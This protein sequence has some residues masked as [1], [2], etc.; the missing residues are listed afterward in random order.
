MHD[1]D[2]TSEM[3]KAAPP[4]TVSGLTIAG[5]PIADIVQLVTLIYVSCLL[6]KWLWDRLK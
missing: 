3:I 5:I 6:G 2:F 4:V 1:T